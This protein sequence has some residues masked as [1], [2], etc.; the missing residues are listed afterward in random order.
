MTVT[1]SQHNKQRIARQFSRAATTYD[2]A[3]D[4]QLDIAFEAMNLL[5][6][7]ANKVLDIGCGTGRISQTLA[8][9]YGAIVAMDLAFG[10]LNFAQQQNTQQSNSIQWLQGDA[11]S[12]PLANN[13]VDL[14]FSSMALQWCCNQQQV[15]AEVNRVLSKQG[16]A[17]LAIMCDGSFI[18]LNHCW[19]QI[20]NQRHINQ[21]ATATSWKVAAK[22]QGLQVEMLQS[23]FT[24]WHSGIRALLGSIKD[25]GANVL[26][27]AKFTQLEKVKSA[28]N[29]T[30]L[31][32]L[33]Q[34]YQQ[35]YAQASQLP[36]TY[37]VCFLHCTKI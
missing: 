6:K 16:Q 22:Q 36:L 32:Q 8:G 24:T 18:E 25:I 10:M 19:R 30:S 29:R 34:F 28:L 7:Q 20:D 23:S 35:E 17:V 27:E 13:S 11:E 15:M 37:Q 14:V 31:Q 3:A 12:L 4:V 26:L 5:P 2:S 21:F 9:R 1:Y 33:E